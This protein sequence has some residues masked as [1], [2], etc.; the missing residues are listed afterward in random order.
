M[1]IVW[2]KTTFQP[3]FSTPLSAHGSSRFFRPKIADG[4]G[5]KQ[6]EEVSQRSWTF[7]LTIGQKSEKSERIRKIEGSRKPEKCENEFGVAGFVNRGRQTRFRIFGSFVNPRFFGSVRIFNQIGGLL[8]PA[9][10]GFAP[11]PAAILGQ[12]KPHFSTPFSF[13]NPIFNFFQP[14]F[15]DDTFHGHSMGEN[16]FSTPLFNPTFSPRLKQ[17]FPP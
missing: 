17:I 8:D 7:P 13:F 11:L 9:S 12:F 3:R 15:A 16:D 5:E 2:G 10:D 4:R 1:A 6:P 14:R